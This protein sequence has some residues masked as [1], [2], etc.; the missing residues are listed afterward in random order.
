M[1]RSGIAGA[2]LA[3]LVAAVCIR[4]G[5][6]QLDRLEQR[7]ERNAAQR[8]ALALPPLELTGD[9]LAAV[10]ADPA[11]FLYRRVRASGRYQPEEEVV[12]RGR[13]MGGR[14]GVHLLTPLRLESGA[15][16]LVL[17]GW[18][19]S[20][21]GA[22]VELAPLR[23]RAPR[24]VEGI[25]LLPPA[26]VENPRARE[27]DNALS[28]QRL[29]LATVQRRATSAVLPLYLQQLPTPADPELPARLPLPEM[30]D[31]GPHL[32]YAVQWFS[33]AA[34]ALGGFLLLAW[35]RRRGR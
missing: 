9:S 15:S 35:R 14:P 3:V 34:I 24:P 21:D 23:E 28:L 27:V 16:L 4:L 29:D 19:P 30:D 1:S 22:T 12:L 2:V 8:E 20:P 11:R 18:A 13:S 7:R 32:G 25:V 33:F 26:E 17:R 31:D 10:A 6:W 5:F